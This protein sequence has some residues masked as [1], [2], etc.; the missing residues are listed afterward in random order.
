MDLNE[1]QQQASKTATFDDLAVDPMLYV[2]LGL[3]GEAGEVAEKVKK[4]L[5]NDNGMLTDEKREGLKYELGDVLWYVSQLARVLGYTL[6]DVAKA[7]IAK[8]ADR[9][10]R[11]VIK[12]EGDNR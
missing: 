6:E 4:M 11:G 8:L 12:S 10:A 7:N 3:T 1:Y 2:T 5:R 9:A